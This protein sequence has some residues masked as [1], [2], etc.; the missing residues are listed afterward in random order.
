MRFYLPS[1]QLLTFDILWIGGYSGRM[2]RPIRVEF[3]D[4]VYHVTARGNE[5][6]AIYRDD[7]DRQ[8]FLET[9][10]QAHDRFGWSRRADAV[11][12]SQRVAWLAEQEADRRVAMWLRVRLGGERMTEVAADYGY[13]DGSMRLVDERMLRNLR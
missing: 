1:A 12:V 7:Q 6:K 10:E 9:V 5:R 4:A 2:A 13:R 3:A 11:Q 8:R